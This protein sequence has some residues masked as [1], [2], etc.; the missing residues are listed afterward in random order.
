MNWHTAFVK[1]Q[2]IKNQITKRQTQQLFNLCALYNQDGSLMLDIG[3]Y[4][5]YSASIMA[6]AAP[7]ATIIT[8]NP[9]E[10]EVDVARANLKEYANVKVRQAH[11]WDLLEKWEE[12]LIDFIFVDGDHNKVGRDLGWY[13]HLVIGGLMIFHDYNPPGCGAESPVLRCVLDAWIKKKGRPFDYVL[14]DEDRN[15]GMVGVNRWEEHGE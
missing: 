5:G 7:R 14:I 2:I 11:S 1:S 6:Q 13:K 10:A 4:H 12:G 15:R 3:T 8:C 9:V